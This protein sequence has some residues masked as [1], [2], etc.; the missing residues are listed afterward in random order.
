M[1]DATV[2]CWGG[3]FDGELGDGAPG[4]PQATPK[5]VPGLSGVVQ[6]AVRNE[7]MCAARDREAPCWGY[8]SH[9]QLGDGTTTSKSVPTPV[10]W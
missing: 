8:N 1:K 9:G 4:L 5:T 10:V 2:K 3:N 7:D 6:I